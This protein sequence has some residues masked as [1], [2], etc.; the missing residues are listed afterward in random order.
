M[1][2]DDEYDDD[3]DETVSAA[4]E[5]VPAVTT[6]A[7]APAPAPSATRPTWWPKT[8]VVP[9]DTVPSAAFRRGPLIFKPDDSA[10]G[11]G[12]TICM[13]RRDLQRQEEKLV[14]QSGSASSSS[15]GSPGACGVVQR[16][17]QD[18]MLL[19]GK[20]FDLRLYVLVLG[21][22]D[23][24]IWL[25]KEGLARVCPEPYS[26]P[27]K[28]NAHKT[29]VHLTNY[30]LAKYDVGFDHADDPNDGM[31]GTKR[32][33][34]AVL[35]VLQQDG[36]PDATVVWQRLRECC[37]GV[38][39]RMAATVAAAAA[40]GQASYKSNDLLKGF[41]TERREANIDV[42]GLQEAVSTF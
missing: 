2:A 31:A 10:Q 7:P 34:S 38:A 3:D 35:Q 16:Y 30:S 29:N 1:R 26:K 24:K 28:S 20:K 15:V 36:G 41:A 14:T 13:N 6:A 4:Q 19:D 39:S 22:A 25:L 17:V 23:P 5:V 33:L 12:I 37:G 40:A 9:V 8:W 18:T 11:D 27:D 42:V 32:S 21:A